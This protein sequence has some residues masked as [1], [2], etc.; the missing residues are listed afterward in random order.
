LLPPRLRKVVLNTG[1]RDHKTLIVALLEHKL[2][3]EEV[4][5][6]GC[7]AGHHSPEVFH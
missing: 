6:V 2:T 4:L 7:H 1:Q 5:G 3:L